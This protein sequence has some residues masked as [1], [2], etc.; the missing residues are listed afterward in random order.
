MPFYEQVKAV[1][2][3]LNRS[4]ERNWGYIPLTIA[5]TRAILTHFHTA[6]CQAIPGLPEKHSVKK[7][8]H[9]QKWESG[10]RRYMVF[11]LRALLIVT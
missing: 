11:S 9:L 4:L 3:I 7:N 6:A 10:R 8:S 2:Y 1:H 5:E